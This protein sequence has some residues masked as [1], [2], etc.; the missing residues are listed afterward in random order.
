VPGKIIEQILLEAI[1]SR[2]HM[3]DSHHSFTKGKSCLTNLVAFCDEVTT[4]VDKGRAVDIIYLGSVRP[5]RQSSTTL[6][7][8]NWRNTDLTCGLLSG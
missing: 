1:A 2:R 6:F 3:E 5:L 8:L 4:T 7:S